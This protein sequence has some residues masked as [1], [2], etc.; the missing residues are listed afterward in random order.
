[1]GRECETLDNGES[2]WR[3][4]PVLADQFSAAAVQDKS[5]SQSDQ[6]RIVELTRDWNEVR[7]KVDGQHQVP[8]HQDEGELADARNAIVHQESPEENEAI[9]NEARQRARFTPTPN[10]AQG[11]HDARVDAKEHHERK[12]DRAYG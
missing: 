3:A 8:E 10:D 7:D 4:G 1:M 9:G 2:L 5:E 12:E 6:D 11:E